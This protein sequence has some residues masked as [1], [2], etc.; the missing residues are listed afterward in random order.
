MP[1]YGYETILQHVHRRSL[2]K[3]QV[4]CA[5][6]ITRA[7]T[8]VWQVHVTPGSLLA[9]HMC[10]AS[11]EGC[12]NTDPG[13]AQWIHACSQ[14]GDRWPGIRPSNISTCIVYFRRGSVNQP[15]LKT[16]PCQPGDFEVCQ[17]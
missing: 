17:C 12:V 14:G 16:L 13:L 15:L 2:N 10:A 4:R 1:R 7:Y 8:W 3:W 6:C 5:P 9:E 11:L